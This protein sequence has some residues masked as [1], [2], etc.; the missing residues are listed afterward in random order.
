MKDRLA[1][2]FYSL[3]ICV[4]ICLNSACSDINKDNASTNQPTNQPCAGGVK[5]EEYHLYRSSKGEFVAIRKPAKSAYLFE[6][7]INGINYK[8]YQRI[9]GDTLYLGVKNLQNDTWVWPSTNGDYLGISVNNKV[10][11]LIGG[12][13]KKV[14]HNK[15]LCTDGNSIFLRR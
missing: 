1:N 2:Q 14:P 3:L 11:A 6:F 4:S 5:N 12:G 15:E 9:H 10:Y 7:E 8:V 13:G